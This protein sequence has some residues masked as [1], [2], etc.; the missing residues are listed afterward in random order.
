MTSV[1]LMLKKLIAKNLTD[2]LIKNV[3]MK[4]FIS[5]I[6]AMA[7]PEKYELQYSSV[8]II[9]SRI[10]SKLATHPIGIA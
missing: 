3:D 8:I 10:L 1:E 7:N 5:C 9:S 2:L 6:Y 4:F